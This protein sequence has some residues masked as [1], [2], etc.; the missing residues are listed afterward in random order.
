MRLSNS[1]CK[2]WPVSYTHLDGYKR[3][4]E[5]YPLIHIRTHNT[6]LKKRLA[7]YAGQHPDQCRQTDTDP[8][9]GCMEF[10]IAKGRFSFRL[11]DVYKRQALSLGER[12]LLFLVCCR[13]LCAS[14]EPY[15]YEAVAAAFDCGGH[16]FTAKGKRILSEG[17]REIDRIFRASLKE[18][19]ADGDGGTLP[20][21]TEGQ[22][23]DGAE[24][25]V[26]EHFT[27]PPK[28]YSEAICCERGISCLL[29]TSRCV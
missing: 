26:T 2:H 29:Y 24:V 8:D 9:T 1:K 3:Q 11:T 16:S 15:V 19:P 14:A 12:E 22:T 28:P 6:D 27:Q 13:L 21:F 10:D 7:A 25:S 23:F 18:K 17:W 5:K 20:D 4:D